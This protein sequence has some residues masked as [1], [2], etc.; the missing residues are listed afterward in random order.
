MEIFP[1]FR[2][3]NTKNIWKHLPNKTLMGYP[4]VDWENQAL[5]VGFETFETPEVQRYH[6]DMIGSSWATKK[7]KYFPLN[8]CCLIPI[9]SMGR[10]VYLP[11]LIMNLWVNVGT[12]TGPMDPAG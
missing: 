4:S 12:H 3:E 9:G 10:T 5:Q 1:N 6:D 2:R 11:T 7:K 8:P